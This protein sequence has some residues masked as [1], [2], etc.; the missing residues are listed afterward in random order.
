MKRLLVY[1][2]AVFGAFSALSAKPIDAK[3]DESLR[4]RICPQPKELEFFEGITVLERGSPLSVSTE[5]A[6]SDAE[7][8]A[9]KGDIARYWRVPL[10]IAFAENK[11]N[12][13][14]G[15]EGSLVKIGGTISI[16][17][18]D[19]I[20]ARQALKTLRQF[21]EARKNADGFIFQNARIKDF[22]S[23]KFRGMH[24]CVFPETTMEQLEKYIRL[25]A[26][27]KFNYL[28]IEPWGVF[29]YESHPEFGYAQKKLDRA[30]FKKLINLCYEL[31]ITPIPQVS[32]LGHG[33]QSRISTAKNAVLANH[34]ELEDVF[35]IYG[36]SYCMTNPKAEKI[37]KDLIAEIY[38]FYGRPPFVHLGCDEAYDMGSCHSCRQYGIAELL[39]DHLKKFNAYVNN[40]GARSIIWHDMLL[41]SKDPRWKNHVAGGTAEIAKALEAL[42]KNIVIADWQ[43]SYQDKKMTEFATPKHFKDAG[44]DVLVCPWEVN[45]G[46]VALANTA[47]RDNL[48]GFLETTWHHLAG[49]NRFFSFFYVSGDAAWNGGGVVRNTQAVRHAYP[50][51]KHLWQ[52][53]SDIPALPYEANGSSEKQITTSFPY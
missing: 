20:G 32:I 17:A 48:F 7:K 51:L 47:K 45:T 11:A 18:K 35:E 44:Y 27:Y 2:F 24:L 43:Y 34:P 19:A 37:L 26:Y 16:D 15:L 9:I 42:P 12:G 14:L 36:W 8:A 29:P 33:T 50:L 41:D 5:N 30:K 46:I 31:G 13:Q 25:A 6:L 49:N 40:L 38:D 21:A 39:A 4:D 3:L 1:I 22:A 10:N 28:V 23:L 53:G 52:I